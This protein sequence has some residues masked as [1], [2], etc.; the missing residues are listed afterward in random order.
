MKFN[1]EM[2][3][4][5]AIAFIMVLVLV[6]GLR[7]LAFKVGLV[8]KP[9]YR[10]L[11]NNA[12]PLTGGISIALAGTMALLLSK[13][14]MSGIHENIYMLSGGFLLLIIGTI[15]DRMEI[16]PLYRL[17]IQFGC[18]YMMA[19]SGLRITSLY[20]F[21]GIWE[22]TVV[23]QYALTIFVIVGVI[24]AFNLMDGIDG[25][26]GSLAVV[27]FIAFS[28]VS[29]AFGRFE[30]TILFIA[31][32][33]AILGFLRFNL[34][35]NKIFMGDGGSLFLGFILVVSGI[36]LIEMTNVH[37][38]MDQSLILMVVIS[39]FLVPVLDSIRVYAGRMKQGISPF[40]ADRSHLHHLFL[41]AG[42]SHKI[43][44]MAIVL[45]T[46]FLLVITISLAFY[47]P[48]TIV[49]ILAW[50]SFKLLTKLL[51]TNKNLGEW[52]NKI[53]QMESD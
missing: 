12:I 47:F 13:T 5:G 37:H 32:I 22:I 33:G 17:I 1:I 40:S 27:G 4:T 21:F 39:I 23:F 9:N 51:N 34:S 38:G 19:A 43:T 8:D 24:N 52:K 45:S 28:I 11:H 36:Q 48:M 50:L 26:A 16:R 7:N 15:D 35:K 53:T 29:Y 41:L 49:L 46:I 18:A 2:I 42:L 3:I 44:A 25:L 20:G 6:P 10:K 31:L 14:F 30:Y